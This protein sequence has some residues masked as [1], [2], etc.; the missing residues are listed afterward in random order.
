MRI[1]NYSEDYFIVECI[2]CGAKENLCQIAF[3]A[4]KAVTGY[5][6]SCI[7]CFE[8]LAKKVVSVDNV[9]GKK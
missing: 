1:G 4:D 8:S 9:D 6:F 2:G 5:I 7:N 3:R